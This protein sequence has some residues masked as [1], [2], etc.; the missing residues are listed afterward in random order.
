M[1]MKKKFKLSLNLI[2]SLVLVCASVITLCL[3]LI[4]NNKN[5]LKLEVE[6]IVVTQGQSCEVKYTCNKDA[7]I[8]I[9]IFNQDIASLQDNIITGIRIGSTSI[10][11]TATYQD[12]KV[13]KS[14]NVTVNEDYD[15]KIT[16]LPAKITLYQLDKN[17]EIANL[18]GFYNEKAYEELRPCDYEISSDE[19][20][21]VK[22]AK[23][24]IK[25]NKAGTAVI[26]FKANNSVTTQTVEVEVKSIAPKLAIEQTNFNL[27]VNESAEI[28]YEITPIYYTGEAEISFDYNHDLMSVENGMLTALSS[29]SGKVDVY[30][31]GEFVHTI[32]VNIY[33][34]ATLNIEQC[35]NCNFDS[36][37]LK[38][39]RGV[40]ASFV[41]KMSA[42][43]NDLSFNILSGNENA[44]RRD[45]NIYYVQTTENLKIEFYSNHLNFSKIITIEVVDSL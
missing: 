36:G 5:D 10:K 44:I 40:E 12:D 3:I 26:T 13:T 16:D 41:V 17:I 34:N 43:A 19:A 4:P 21:V 8:K 27:I 45:L 20:N 14:A 28:E 33:S 32:A 39:L 24:V 38:V 11:I 9:E 18:D 15:G 7:D 22:I 42:V 1:G 2:I 31:N 25:A 35:H 6:D 23:N 37:V 30:L 29:G